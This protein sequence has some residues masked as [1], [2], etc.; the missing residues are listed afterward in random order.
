MEPMGE[1]TED[2]QEITVVERQYVLVTHKRHK[3]RCRCNAQ[4]Q[5][6]PGPLKLIPG[7]RYSLEFAIQVVLDKYLFHLPLERQV[8]MML[9]LGLEVDSQT[10][11]DQIQALERILN[12]AYALI[13]AHLL[14]AQVLHADETPWPLLKKG[15][16]QTLYQIEQ[17]LPALRGL[18]G[19]DRERALALRARVRQEQSA[20][21][22][23]KLYDWAVAQPALRRR[24]SCFSPAPRA[25][26]GGPVR[27][28]CSR[29]IP[30]TRSPPWAGAAVGRCS[31]AWMRPNSWPTWPNRWPRQATRTPWPSC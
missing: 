17:G 11:W 8:R 19:E 15:G 1:Q 3:Y 12:P 16:S 4:V 28:A 27:S 6:A 10:L 9:R 2:C 5:T 13:H 29:T 25:G 7:G 18:Q 23:Q 26:D 21:R 31:F 22:M 24:T 20:P 14:S 30:L